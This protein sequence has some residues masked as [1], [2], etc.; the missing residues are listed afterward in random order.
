MSNDFIP[1][2]KELRLAFPEVSLLLETT[3]I[4]SELRRLA[5][6]LKPHCISEEPIQIDSLKPSILKERKNGAI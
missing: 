3:R 5:I 1:A 4:K 6:E 2:E